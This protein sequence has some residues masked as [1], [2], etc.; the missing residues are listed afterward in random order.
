MRISLW[1]L[2][3]VTAA[4]ALCGCAS[5]SVFSLQE[6]REL[7][8]GG[9][10][11]GRSL[12]VEEFRSALPRTV[13]TLYHDPESGIIVGSGE[14][15][16]PRAGRRV[17]AALEKELGRRGIGNGL[18]I[19]GQ[20]LSEEGGNVVLRSIVGLGI[21][22]SRLS[23]RTLVFNESKSHSKPWLIIW[24]EG[25]SGREP[26]A[27]FSFVPPPFGSFV[28]PLAAGGAGLALLS[29]GPKGP[30]QDA[31]RTAKVVADAIEWRM[32]PGP[33]RR[34]REPK[35]LG[36]AKLPNGTSIPFTRQGGLL[37]LPQTIYSKD[38]AGGGH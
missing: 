33:K 20:V 12:V 11:C 19:A 8:P 16:D 32:L 30:G 14:G 35:L 5:S 36:V 15:D 2:G 26:G 24:T 7:A 6:S 10:G 25:G 3:A 22:G 18:R 31:G 37:S 13:E 9:G 23:T 1:R 27:A 17:A 4:L 38:G 34:G 21:G 28:L 29:H